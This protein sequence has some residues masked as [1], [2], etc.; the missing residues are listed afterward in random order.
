MRIRLHFLVRM[1]MK[2]IKKIFTVGSSPFIT[3]SSFVFYM[4][5]MNNMVRK[6]GGYIGLSAMGVFLSLDSILFLPALAI[7]EAVQ[8]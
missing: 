3:N 4:T 2:V 7:G 6:Y 8:R 5:L 1:K